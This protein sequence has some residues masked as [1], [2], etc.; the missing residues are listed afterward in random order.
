MPCGKR[1]EG[2]YVVGLET[3]GDGAWLR[4]E[5]GRRAYSDRY[6]A[7][8]NWVAL[9]AGDGSDGAA[10]L[11]RVAAA[12]GARVEVRALEGEAPPADDEAMIGG[13]G[14]AEEAAPPTRRAS[15]A[16]EFLDRPFVPRLDGAEPP[17]ATAPPP[18]RRP[19]PR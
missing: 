11:T 16:A 13:A 14:A 17:P 6:G 1:A 2:E 5:P 9:R 18:P 3:K 10:P 7:S 4:I 8:Q 12:D 19:P 15:I